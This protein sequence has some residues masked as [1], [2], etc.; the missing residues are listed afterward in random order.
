MVKRKPANLIRA[1]FW[2]GVFE[3]IISFSSSKL[4][5]DLSHRKIFWA[6]FLETNQSFLLRMF[7]PDLIRT[8][9]RACV[10]EGI[11]SF[12]SSKLSPDPLHRIFSE[13][14]SLKPAS[15]FHCKC[16]KQTSSVRNYELAF[17]NGSCHFQHQTCIPDLFILT[18][19][20]LASLTR[21]R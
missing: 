21:P 20:D 10:L 9:F 13:Q 8:N 16:F 18:Y 15:H 7:E 1:K 5:P 6:G 11:M 4:F 17:L 12:S 14:A 19:I 3:G 2:A